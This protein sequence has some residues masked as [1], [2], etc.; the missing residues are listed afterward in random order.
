MK[1]RRMRPKRRG[2]A[3][4]FRRSGS[5]KK[6]SVR[7]VFVRVFRCGNARREN[8]DV[9]SG[10]RTERKCRPSEIVQSMSRKQSNDI[11]R[12]VRRTDETRKR[13]VPGA[14]VGRMIHG[15]V[16]VRLGIDSDGLDGPGRHRFR[17]RP[18]REERERISLGGDKRRFFHDESVEKESPAPHG[19]RC[20]PATADHE[21][22]IFFRHRQN[23][24]FASVVCVGRSHG[25]AK[26]LDAGRKRDSGGLA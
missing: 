17:E 12:R 1:A 22:S 15:A 20:P 25:P 14:S 5:A 3:L 6:D 8:L 21:D 19:I 23:K 9:E 4:R 26:R 13:C 10:H 7:V 2:F 18:L 16:L 24:L 11:G